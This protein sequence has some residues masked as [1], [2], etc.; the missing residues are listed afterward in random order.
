M[1]FGARELVVDLHQNGPSN[2]EHRVVGPICSGV[3]VSHFQIRTGCF[4]SP[5]S[6]LPEQRHAASLIGFASRRAFSRKEGASSGAGLDH[7]ASPTGQA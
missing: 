6:I 2:V 5:P 7:A 1:S 3:D 4:R